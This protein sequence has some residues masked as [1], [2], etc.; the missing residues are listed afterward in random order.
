MLNDLA[1]NIILWIVIAIVLLTVFQSFGT[2]TRQPETVD[3][4]EFLDMVN[5]GQVNQVVFEG[6][7]IRGS[8]SSGD[9]FTTHSPET[10]NTALIG[11]LKKNNVR[12]RATAPKGQNLLVSLFINSFPVLLLI[13]VWVYFMRQMQ[14]TGGGRGAMSF[15][16]SRA[17]LLGED[18]VKVTFVDVAGVEEAKEE[19][20]EIVDFLKDPAKFQRLGGKIP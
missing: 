11:E 9:I 16:K 13:A 4:S 15:G 12:F 19:V 18:Q 17:R 2:G 14:G 20:S 1:K 8:R 6:E 7:T 3:Y 10:D 5:S